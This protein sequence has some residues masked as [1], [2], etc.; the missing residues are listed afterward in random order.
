MEFSEIHLSPVRQSENHS[1]NLPQ[2]HGP[3]GGDTGSEPG[4]AAVSLLLC[5]C[6]PPSVS[7]WVS[8]VCFWFFVHHSL[9]QAK[10]LTWGPV[11]EIMIRANV[12]GKLADL[13]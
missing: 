8:S 12:G 1:G 9:P 4:M 3:Q 10:Y 13:D 2:L 7:I 6:Q 5:Q 11:E